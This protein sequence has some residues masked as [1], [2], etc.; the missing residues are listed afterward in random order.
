MLPRLEGFTDVQAVADPGGAKPSAWRTHRACLEALPPDA[1]HLLVLQDDAWPCDRFHQRAL[2]VLEEK[3]ARIVSLFVPG[4][5]HIRRQVNIARKKGSRWID[6]D[7][8]GFVPIVAVVY[9]AD[10]VA[11][12]LTFA[13][14][15]R[16][17][18]VRADDAVIAS[19]CRATRT[20]PAAPLPS[21]VEHRDELPSVMRM[22]YGRGQ[23][24]RVAAWFA[25]TVA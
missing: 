5:S 11:A 10:T 19:Y 1:T 25:D 8:R 14:T 13:D 15:I 16:M 3:P 18:L 2:A 12:I 4:F 6:L 24:H 21:L 17:P 7:A 23:P 20:F 22:P 9:P